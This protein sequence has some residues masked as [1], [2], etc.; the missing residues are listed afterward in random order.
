MPPGMRLSSTVL[1]APDA[2]DLAAFYVALLGWE[3]VDDQ[4]GWVKIRPSG[5][6]TGLAFQTE[7]DYVRPVWPSQPGAQQMQ[8]HLDIGADDLDDAESRAVALGATL[9]TV[10]PQDDVRVY[11]DPAGHPFCL[12]SALG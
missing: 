4:P 7:R 5:A 2:K 3:I 11:L 9:A 1:G 8:A 12:F 10:Q 6:I